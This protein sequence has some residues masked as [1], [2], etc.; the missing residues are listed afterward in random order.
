LAKTNSIACIK[1]SFFFSKLP[2][3]SDEHFHKHYAH[4]H[5]DLTVAAKIFGV[6]QIQ[7]YTQASSDL[8]K[9]I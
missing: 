3:V 1:I 2:D 5:A 8:R 7:R 4:V 9:S 6:Y